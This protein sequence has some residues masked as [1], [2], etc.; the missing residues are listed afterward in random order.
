[1]SPTPLEDIFAA[2]QTSNDENFIHGIISEN[3][4][5]ILSHPK[6]KVILTL[7]EFL[8]EKFV[9]SIRQLV[10]FD[11]CDQFDKETLLDNNI[12]IDETDPLKSLR[13][14]Y[15]PSKCYSDIQGRIQSTST[16]SRD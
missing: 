7:K 10:F 2:I 1:M 12:V 14:R 3:I 15:K 16:L 13:K 5:E 11:F 8:Q 4:P 9:Y 6:E